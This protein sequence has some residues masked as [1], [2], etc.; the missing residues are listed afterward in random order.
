MAPQDLCYVFTLLCIN[1]PAL[2]IEP[3]P[4][5]ISS[6]GDLVSLSYRRFRLHYKLYFK[7]LFWPSL[8]ASVGQH[9]ALFCFMQWL[10]IA[11]HSLLA[12]P[13]FLSHMALVMLGVFV[14][15]FSLL[16]LCMRCSAMVRTELGLESTYADSLAALKKR[17]GT[18]FLVYNLALFPPLVCL[19]VCAV[20]MFMTVNIITSI[21]EALRLGVSTVF[22]G[23]IGF[24]STVAISITSLAASMLL[25]IVTFES[26]SLIDSCKRTYF[27]LRH[28]L[29]RG[30]SFAC[31]LGIFVALIYFAA[32][33]PVQIAYVIEKMNHGGFNSTELPIYLQVIEAAFDTVLTIVIFAVTYIGYGFFYRDLKLRLEGADITSRVDLLETPKV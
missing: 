20:L 19:V 31:L 4:A 5:R 1:L 33:S 2:V 3:P 8:L 27:L 23:V 21:P 11:S 17:L 25:A 13:P 28:R 9:M 29:W 32:N 10:K 6:L 12:W 24:V 14:W 22:Y 15:F 26:H 7:I 18:I 30:G 16:E